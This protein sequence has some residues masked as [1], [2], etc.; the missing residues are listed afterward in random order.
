[1]G[2]V[3]DGQVGI[4]GD[5]G[6][7]LGMAF[8]ITDDLLDL[9]GQ[10]ETLGKPL[11]ND[12]REGRLTLPFIH[13]MRVAGEKDRRWMAD[14]FRGGQTD[15]DAL[16]RMRSM[17]EEYGGVEYSLEKAKEYGG[18]CKGAL[19][20]LQ[21]SESRTSLTMLADYVVERVC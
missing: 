4:L 6:L 7:D 1:M 11:G 10:K 16:S 12:I 21:E 20:S 2:Q 5:Y 18:A 17:V 8:Q 13:A 14:A 9:T 3:A 15:G 19:R